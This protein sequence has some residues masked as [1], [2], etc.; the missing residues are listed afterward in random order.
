[1]RQKTLN[2]YLD[3]TQL[4]L[5]HSYF[6]PLTFSP[7]PQTRSGREI[8][9]KMSPQPRALNTCPAKRIYHRLIIERQYVKNLL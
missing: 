2:I 3:D 1:M 9:P 4:M 7:P 8:F 5:F 6:L